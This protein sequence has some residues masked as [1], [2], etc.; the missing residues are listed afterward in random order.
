MKNFSQRKNSVPSTIGLCEKNSIS[1]HKSIFVLPCRTQSLSVPS[2]RPANL[3]AP[4]TAINISTN[5]RRFFFRFVCFAL[6]IFDK[7]LFHV[8][9]ASFQMLFFSPRDVNQI[10]ESQRRR[11]LRFI[12][13]PRHEPSTHKK[14]KT[15]FVLVFL[16]FLL[17]PSVH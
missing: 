15:K 2:S 5:N 11:K 7:D 1:I 9:W 12:W 3:S 17:S 10:V 13:N 8:P 14:C 4:T 6:L 16:F